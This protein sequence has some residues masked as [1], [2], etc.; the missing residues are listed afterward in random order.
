M[1]RNSG[2]AALVLLALWAS[3]YTTGQP[4]PPTE[5]P[6]AAPEAAF[7]KGYYIYPKNGQTQQQ[8]W[9]DRYACDN[10][11]K[12]QSGFDP[13]RPGGG[14]PP[15]ES[16]MRRE[17]YRRAMTA[18]LEAHGYGVEA[19]PQS[20]Q[21]PPAS[22]PATETAAAAPPVRPR[23]ESSWSAGPELKYHPLSMTVQ[24]GYVLT[25]G[26]LK[27]TLDD[28]GTVGLGLRWF[29]TS[30][31]PLGL[32]IDGSYS[33]FEETLASLNQVATATGTNVVFGH[34]EVY[35]G[36][37]DVQLDLA[38]RSTRYKMYLFGGFGWYRQYTVFKQQL[39]GQPGFICGYYYGCGYGYIGEIVPVER[40]TTAWERSWNAGFGAEFALDDPL[41]FFI[42]ARYLRIAPYGSNTAF[43]PISV[44]LRF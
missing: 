6:S 7:G 43:I 42:E 44:G 31:L 38:H 22:L 35:G 23:V 33:R 10:W 19:A 5:P 12:S 18:C 28:G 24:A 25:E 40:S 34:Q 26:A 8:Q 15:Q 16:A 9:A 21:P 3:P 20:P 32:R 37:A 39:A 1:A 13:A 11:S 27:P 14:V 17:Q 4:A 41:T 36:D 2:T 29:P 30:Q